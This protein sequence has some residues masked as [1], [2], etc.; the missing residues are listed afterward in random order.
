MGTCL[1]PFQCNV[2]TEN[3]CKLIKIN[4]AGHGNRGTPGKPG[5]PVKPIGSTAAVIPP[6]AD[7]IIET[8]TKGKELV[9]AATPADQTAAT[10]IG[11]GN[12]FPGE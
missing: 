1:G 7:T 4:P 5:K 12:N 2:L 8:V 3:N 6:V 9:G 10:E 11:M